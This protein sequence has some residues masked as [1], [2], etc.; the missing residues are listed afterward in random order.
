MQ[1][2]KQGGIETNVTR[3]SGRKASMASAIGQTAKKKQQ[4]TTGFTQ[5]AQSYI[6][7]MTLACATNRAIGNNTALCGGGYHED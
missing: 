2:Q 6:T 7:E 4:S 3:V 1:V 5:H